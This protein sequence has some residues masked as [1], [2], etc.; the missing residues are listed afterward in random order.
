MAKN[1]KGGFDI[2][3]LLINPDNPF[4]FQGTDQEWQDFLDKLKR[5]PEFLTAR[6]IVYDSSRDNLILGGNKRCQGLIELGVFFV[7]PQ[8]VIDCKGWSDEKKRRFEIA[9]NWHPDGSEWDFD[10]LETEEIEEWGLDFEPPEEEKDDTPFEYD[11]NIVS[12]IYKP[13]GE[14]PPLESLFND[15]KAQELI[16]KVEKSKLSDEVKAFLKLAAHRH[17]VFDYE[18]IAD[19]YANATKKEKALFE[20]SMLVIVDYQ[21]AIEGGFLKV[22][23]KFFEQHKEENEE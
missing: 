2:R 17:V 22:M 6:P 5:D 21:K 16:G 10:M 7:D 1:K 15:D 3:T 8:N 18:N 12:P 19:Y 4:P 23:D 20:E 9:D 11:Q 14:Q 13:R